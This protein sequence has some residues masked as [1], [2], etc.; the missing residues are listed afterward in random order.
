MKANLLLT[1]Q[2]IDV[3]GVSF[4]Q[5]SDNEVT[6][7]WHSF[8]FADNPFMLSLRQAIDECGWV[9]FQLS[10]LNSRTNELQELQE[11]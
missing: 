7:E 1:F 8:V 10:K 6:M 2:M 4:R 3:L 5:R 9:F 11:E